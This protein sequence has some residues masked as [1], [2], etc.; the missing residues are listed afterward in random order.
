ME[1]NWDPVYLINLALCIVIF[2]L[3]YW[4]YRKRRDAMPLLIG[5]AFGLF[6]ISHLV[7]IFG[8]ASDLASVLIV[9]RVFAYLVVILA[10]YKYMGTKNERQRATNS[11]SR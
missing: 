7:T 3:G 1:F 6:G 11:L 8:L 2:L 9:I 4:G 10:L 5:V